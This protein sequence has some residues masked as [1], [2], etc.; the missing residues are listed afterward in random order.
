MSKVKKVS[1]GEGGVSLK[2]L[3]SVTLI[4]KKGQ[5]RAPGIHG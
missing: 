4:Q 5:E 2:P 3:Q 1:S